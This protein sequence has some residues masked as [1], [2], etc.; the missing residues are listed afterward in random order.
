MIDNIDYYME[1]LDGLTKDMPEE[2]VKLA[3]VFEL[4]VFEPIHMEGEDDIY[5][6]YLMNDSVESY[7][8]FENSVMTGEYKDIDCDQIA[9]IEKLADGYMLIV[10]QGGE[11]TFTIRFKELKLRTHL[12]NYGCMGHFWIDGYEYLRQLEYQFADIRDKYR[13]LGDEVCSDKEML[14]MKLADFPPI[15]QYRSV[16][17]RYYVPYPDCVYEEAVDYLIE[18]A[19]ATEDYSMERMLVSYKRKPTSIKSRVIARMLCGK[20]HAEL[21]D[22]IISELRE[23]ASIYPDR[24]FTTEEDI[25]RDVIHKKALSSLSEYIKQGYKCLLYREEPFMY[26]RDS[27]TYKEHVLVF[28]NGLFRRKSKIITFE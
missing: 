3:Q 24:T 27:I 2:F 16:P 17:E 21:V 7:F 1:Y 4:N 15:K 6:A 9:V 14:L 8:V 22:A 25:Q 11:N 20:K 13:Y 10:N 19:E 18:L 5:A 28:V 12:F 23:A 26:S